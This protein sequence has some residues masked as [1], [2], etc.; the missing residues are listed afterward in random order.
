MISRLL[1]GGLPGASPSKAIEFTELEALHTHL[2]SISQFQ[3]NSLQRFQDPLSKGFFLHLDSHVP[4][5]FSKA[6]TATCVISLLATG[7][8]ERIATAA[9]KQNLAERLLEATWTS[10]DL[11]PD[12]V[13]TTAFILE[14]ANA[15][16]PD[17]QTARQQALLTAAELILQREL[18]KGFASL[19]GYPSS[20]YLTQL[21]VR[22]LNKRGK[23]DSAMADPIRKWAWSEIHHQL[24]LMQA[25]GKSADAYQLAYTLMLVGELGSPSQTTPEEA[26]LMQSALNTLFDKQLPDGSWPRSQPLFHYPKVGTAYCYEYEMLVQLLSPSSGLQTHLLAFLPNLSRAAYALDPVAFELSETARAWTSGHH[27]Q[28]PGPES[29]A[30][31]SVFHYVHALGRLLAEEIRRW[32]FDHLDATYSPPREQHSPPAEF[33]PALLDSTLEKY[34]SLKKTLLDSFVAPI[35]R[36]AGGVKMGRPLSKETPMSAIFFGPPGTSKTELAELISKYLGWPLLTVDPSYFVRNGLDQVQSEASRLF[37]L[38]SLAEEVVVLLDEFDEMVRDRSSATEVL[39]R[40]L[41]TAMLPKLAVINRKR[42][43]VFIVATN[44]LNNFDLAISRQGR[45]DLL[46]PVMPPSLDEKLRK[47]PGVRAKLAE[48]RLDEDDKIKQMLSDLTFLEFQ[49]LARRLGSATSGPEARK[50]IETFYENAT[51]NSTMASS[52]DATQ[53]KWK[54]ALGEQQKRIRIPE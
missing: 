9:D 39:S 37:R 28:N 42:T 20:G 50:Q 2:D 46:L 16:A 35:A 34:G 40:F 17:A 6:S 1:S 30:T 33:G 11:P 48:Y 51:L 47:W 54:E 41:T 26:L 5:D 36:E 43:I 10:A 38:L 49:T 53:Q 22:A 27:P 7:R 29:W 23:L 31:A 12:N 13:F 14:A 21:A 4:G 18:S 3:V 52:G 19:E 45:F 25:N 15:L 32:I 8:W 24:A 44:Y